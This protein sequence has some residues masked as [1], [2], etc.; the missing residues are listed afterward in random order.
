MNL[1][2]PTVL[3]S[4]CGILREEIVPEL[5]SAHATAQV[6]AVADVLEKLSA[7]ADWSSELLQ[8]KIDRL[9]SGGAAFREAAARHGLQTPE[10]PPATG[11]LA[12]RLAALNGDMTCLTDCLFDLPPATDPALRE[13][14]LR[15]LR[16]AIQ[17]AQGEERRLITATDF[18]ATS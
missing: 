15:I 17:A 2:F 6:V 11:S 14:L 18:S 10:P 5:Q 12:Q 16:D 7:L 1:P 13:R 4:L 8:A 3:S 9:S